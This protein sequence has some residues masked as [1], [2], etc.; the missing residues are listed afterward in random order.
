ME[1]ILLNYGGVNTIFNKSYQIISIEGDQLQYVAR[2]ATGQ[3]Y[4]AFRLKKREGQ[5]NQ[6]IE[7]VPDIPQRLRPPIP[8]KPKRP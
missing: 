3:L 6:L 4:D 8:E 2:T 5:S 7:Q 1:Q